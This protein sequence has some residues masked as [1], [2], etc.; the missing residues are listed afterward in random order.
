MQLT[1]IHVLADKYDV[2]NLEDE[3]IKQ[4]LILYLKWHGP[5]NMEVVRCIYSNT[6]WPSPFCKALL[7]CYAIYLQS[8]W[9]SERPAAGP[10]FRPFNLRST[11]QSLWLRGLAIRN[12]CGAI[13]S[14]SMERGGLLGLGWIGFLDRS[15][16]HC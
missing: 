3:C 8:E 11:T 15:S 9:Y 10:L 13:L 5:P 12:S 6:I 1:N 14:V 16:C 7:D 4:M 2:H